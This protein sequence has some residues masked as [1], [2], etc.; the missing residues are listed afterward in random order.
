MTTTLSKLDT[1]ILEKYWIYH[2][3]N[4]K[5]LSIL[6]SLPITKK[7]A[8]KERNLKEITKAID[9]IYE[10]LDEDYRT[11]VQMRYWDKGEGYEWLEIAD[12]LYMSTQKV[13]RKRNQLMKQTAELIGWI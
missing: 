1:Q 6:K 13:L 11:I 7:E 12:Q 4:K 10:D 2:E 8:L 9:T 3:E 5:Q